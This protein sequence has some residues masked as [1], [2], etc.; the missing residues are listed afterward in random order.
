MKNHNHGM[1][2]TDGAYNRGTKLGGYASLLVF[3]NK[4][5][6][7]GCCVEE[8]TSNRME[9]QAVIEGLRTA[10]KLGCETL[11][12]FSDSE[13]VLKGLTNWS[14]KWRKFGWKRSKNSLDE[15]KNLDLWKEMVELAEG[16]NEVWASHVSGHTGRI[17]NERCDEIAECFAR[18]EYMQLFNG[19]LSE[20]RLAHSIKLFLN[21]KRNWSAG[22]RDVFSSLKT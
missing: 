20:Y 10:E 15:I 5:T 14:R 3:N 11:E 21:P 13:Y 16:F 7:I 8:T 1:L 9:M 12:V 2:F 22:F 4:I 18:E 6:E 17:G 19:N